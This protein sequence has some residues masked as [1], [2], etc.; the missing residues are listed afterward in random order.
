M[1]K[2]HVCLVLAF[3]LVIAGC[4]GMTNLNSGGSDDFIYSDEYIQ[5]HLPS[6]L[7]VTFN[8]DTVDPNGD[9]DLLFGYGTDWYQL[10][11][12]SAGSTV[13]YVV[14]KNAG[15]NTYSCYLKS[16]G[17]YTLVG[18]SVAAT[19]AETDI[20]NYKRQAFGLLANYLTYT[21]HSGDFQK[22]G[23]ETVSGKTCT[24]YVYTFALP[25]ITATYSF[26]LEESTGFCLKS[27]FVTNAHTDDVTITCTN[28]SLSSTCPI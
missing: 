25:Q 5:E 15:T 8:V 4:N 17:P 10:E 13:G 11:I 9:Y 20:S 26:W 1:R 23:T 2:R 6:N 14:K 28:Y 19:E 27:S 22:S 7:K 24:K 21:S 12:T 3:V 16:D 18:D